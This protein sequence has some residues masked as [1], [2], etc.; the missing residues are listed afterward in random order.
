MKVILIAIIALALLLMIGY[1]PLIISG[2]I[3]DEEERRKS[4]YRKG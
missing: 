1:A 3:S 4:D 2:R